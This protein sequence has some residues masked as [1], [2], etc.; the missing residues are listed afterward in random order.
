MRILWMSNAPWCPTGYGQQTG[1]F[2][3]RLQNMGHQMSCFAF[4]GLEYGTLNM[5]GVQFF[6][7]GGDPYG[8]DIVQAHYLAAGAEIIISLMDTWVMQPEGYPTGLIWVPWYPVDHD[9]MPDIVR[10][11]IAQAFKRIVMSKFGVRMT[12]E[13]GLDCYYIP[14]GV[15][16]NIF[17][18]GDKA[19]ARATLHL[20]PDKWIVSTVA[21][22]K[23]SDPSRKNFTEM[24]QAFAAFH[25]VHPDTFWC[26]HSMRG[27]G[28]N[29]V[30][31]IPEMLRLLGL[32]EGQDWAMP[33]QYRLLLGM[34]PS[35]VAELYRASD[36]MMLVS[37]GEGFGIPLLEAQACGCP[38]IT[39][40]WTSNEELCLAGRMIEKR[41]AHKFYTSLASY[42]FLPDPLAIATALDEEYRA[43]TNT[44]QA[45]KQIQKEYDADVIAATMWKPILREIAEKRNEFGEAQGWKQ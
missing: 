41:D 43:R 18:P 37:A 13:A 14:L 22:N 32:I 24:A 19:K 38:V 3:P 29:G 31:N 34:P 35:E 11:K 6:P 1:L 44:E 5:N 20:P 10:G 42:Q 45:V 16:T 7:R 4:A 26:L 28:A 23:G 39:S 33:D 2:L 15:D 36:C 21:M 27:E 17:S 8:N 9:P 25:K 30:V 12:H 40:G